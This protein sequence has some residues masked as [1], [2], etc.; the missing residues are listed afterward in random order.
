LKL[1][2]RKNLEKILIDNLSGSSEILTKLIDWTKDHVHDTTSIQQ[3][4]TVAG[5]EL[6]SF[7]IVTSFLKEL[8]QILKKDDPKLIDKYL[9][10]VTE[11]SKKKY[12]RL[13]KNS[14]PYLK[15]CK[16]IVTL[17]NSKT[18]IEILK[19]LNKKKKIFVTVAE[20]R[21]QL[22][23]R[24]MV[25]ELLKHKINVE[26]IPE[27]LLSDA[28]EKADVAVAGADEIFP[29][30]NVV[31]KIGSRSLA[32]LCKYF[33][34]SF[35][36]LATTDKFS[37]KKQYIPEKRDSSEIWKYSHKHLTKANFYFEV[38]EKKLITKVI[39]DRKSKVKSQ[40][41]KVV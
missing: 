40:K 30:G 37:K 38:V 7:T 31:N 24:I 39:T 4:I 1:R 13:F 10:E 29:N 16:R 21:P 2:S 20:S 3:M 23:G 11:N 5:R 26:I 36:V 27:A 22:E 33:R 18:V 12:S 9:N 6:K 19:R 15:Y 25:K 17:S 28:V 34:K 14:L 32:I 35:Y 8:E 41:S